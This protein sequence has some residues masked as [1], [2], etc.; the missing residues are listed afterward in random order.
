L[1]MKDKGKLLN[2][3]C[4]ATISVIENIF[5]ISNLQLQQTKVELREQ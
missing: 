4:L 5:V 2:L 1:A 3:I